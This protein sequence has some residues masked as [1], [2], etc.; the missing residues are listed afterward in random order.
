LFRL[1]SSHNISFL[2][3]KTNLILSGFKAGY[4]KQRPAQR[5]PFGFA[6]GIP[7]AV[8]CCKPARVDALPPPFSFFCI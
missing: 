1:Q 3:I 5:V 7:C 4:V 6:N 2:Y 8:V